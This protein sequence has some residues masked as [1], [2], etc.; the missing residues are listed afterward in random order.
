M[1]ISKAFIMDIAS[2][3]LF[4]TGCFIALDFLGLNWFFFV[5]VGIF[6]AVA[7]VFSLLEEAVGAPKK[8]Q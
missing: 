3:I 5:S 4:F 6:F 2:I 7:V 1:L 8:A